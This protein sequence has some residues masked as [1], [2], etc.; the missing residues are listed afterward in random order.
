MIMK[1]HELFNNKFK[2]PITETKWISEVSQALDSPLS[3]APTGLSREEL[4]QW[5]TESGKE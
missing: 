4:R 1:L 2:E 3:T 5:I